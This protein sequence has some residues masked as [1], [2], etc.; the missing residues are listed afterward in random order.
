MN[1]GLLSQIH[2]DPSLPVPDLRRRRNILRV[3]KS[4]CIVYYV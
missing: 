3:A 4:S 1:M 2:L